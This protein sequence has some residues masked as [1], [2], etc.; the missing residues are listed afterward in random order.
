MDIFEL[1]PNLVVPPPTALYA[2]GWGSSCHGRGITR[3]C[4]SRGNNSGRAPM[5]M[6]RKYTLRDI[7]KFT[8]DSQGYKIMHSQRVHKQKMLWLN[9]PF[10]A[11]KMATDE[12][13]KK[14]RLH[15]HNACS[16]KC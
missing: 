9:R 8:V 1:F 15:Q 2:H 12:E 5:Q 16:A 13:E 11:A 10:R 7:A 6:P 3:G 4:G 14:H